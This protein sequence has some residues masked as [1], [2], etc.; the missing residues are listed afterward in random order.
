ME[1]S[2]GGVMA[3]VGVGGNTVGKLLKLESAGG[4]EEG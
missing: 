2:L 1:V 4:V 3:S